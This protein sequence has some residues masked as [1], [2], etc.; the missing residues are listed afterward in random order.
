[1]EAALKGVLNSYW[2]TL[3]VVLCVVVILRVTYIVRSDRSSFKIHKELLGLL[4][5]AYL[6]ILFEMV[7]SQ[8]IGGGGTNL[9]PFREILRYDIGT[10]GFYKQV[11]GNILA[12]IPLGY[13]ASYYCKIKN[14][15][16]ITFITLLISLLIEFVQR[17]IGRCFDIDD[18]ILN[19]IGGIIGFLIFICLSAIKKHLPKILQK[20]IIYDIITIFI[21]VLIVLYIVRI[22]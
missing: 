22:F 5:I 10:K 11:V 14:L 12:F 15:G 9:M 4:F 19:V 2:P 8:D 17:F 1:M 3:S 6:L 18:I 20:D 13:F 7:L 16:V 21:G